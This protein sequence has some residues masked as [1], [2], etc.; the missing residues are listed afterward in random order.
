M[1]NVKANRNVSVTGSNILGTK[2]Y[3][4]PREMMYVQIQVKK[5]NVMMYINIGKK[6]GLMGAGIGFTIGSKKSD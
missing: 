2:M 4:Y 5:H 6:S 1:I 3:R